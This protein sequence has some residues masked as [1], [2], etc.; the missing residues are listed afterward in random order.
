MSIPIL[1]LSPYL[2]PRPWG[3]TRLLPLYREE[4]PQSVPIG[5]AWCLSDRPEGPSSVL[6]GPL[7]GM[8]F[9]DVIRRYPQEVVGQPQPPLQYPLLVKYIDAAE[10]LSIQVHPDDA[11]TR[12]RSLSDR[13]KTECWYIMDCQPSSEIIYGLAKGTTREILQEA[14]AEKRVADV[15]RRVPISPGTFLFVPPGTI[16]AILGG[17]LL[18]E[19]QQSSNLTYRLWDWERK[20]ARQL[21]IE[22]SLDVIRFDLDEQPEPMTMGPC[23]HIG[24]TILELT[25]NEFFEV[26][27]LRMS[28]G[29]QT[30]IRQT[31]KGFILNGVEGECTAEGISLTPGGTLFVPACIPEVTLRASQKT[32]VLVSRSMES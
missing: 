5:E 16:H 2:T 29:S 12:T 32:T 11:Y 23:P 8:L 4:E 7:D 22:E 3:G 13:G 21:H 14:I 9:G 6:G 28:A 17:T 30:S 1:R 31:G 26:R 15:V 27:A 20:P 19:I 25:R 18:C 10:D 24:T